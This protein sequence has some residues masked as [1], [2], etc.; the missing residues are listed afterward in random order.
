M[1]LV[2]DRIPQVRRHPQRIFDHTGVRGPAA[3][4]G[5]AARPTRC[6]RTA[7]RRLIGGFDDRP[8]RVRVRDGRAGT[9]GRCP[10]LGGPRGPCGSRGPRSWRGICAVSAHTH[11]AGGWDIP[12]RARCTRDSGR[13]GRHRGPLAIARPGRGVPSPATCQGEKPEPNHDYL[14]VHACSLA[15]RPPHRKTSA[16]PV[17]KCGSACE[18]R[19]PRRPALFLA[20]F[21]ATCSCIRARPAAA[22]DPL[23]LRHESTPRPPPGRPLVPRPPLRPG[24]AARLPHDP[25]LR[26]VCQ[27]PSPARARH[28]QAR[29]T[30]AA[31]ATARAGLRPPQR[32]RRILAH[33]LAQS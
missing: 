2:L 6:P 25:L 17:F 20:Q 14:F 1:Q 10:N 13:A 3:A 33:V 9:G 30:A 11:P 28:P 22:D 12:R 26:C 23:R 7:A 19:H 32:P 16:N 24:P 4:A 27:P 8:G 29:R 31:A 21:L 15:F 5:I 18:G